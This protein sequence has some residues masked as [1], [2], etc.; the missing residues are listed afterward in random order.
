M[1]VNISFD[2]ASYDTDK[3][4]AYIA[5]YLRAF[6]SL[7]DQ[8]VRLLELGVKSGGSLLMWADFFP[9]GEVVGLDLN[10]VSVHHARVHVHRGYQQDVRVL[11]Q[12]GR[13]HAPHGFDIIIDDAS[14]LGEYTAASFSALY[15]HHLVPGGI[16]VLE[17]WGTGYW[18]TWP[19][20]KAISERPRTQRPARFDAS[21]RVVRKASRPAAQKLRSFPQLYARLERLYSATESQLAVVDFPS[22]SA[23]MVGFVKQLVDHTTITDSPPNEGAA[24]PDIAEMWIADGQ[25]FCFKPA[26]TQSASADS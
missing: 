26:Q 25:V 2:A 14:H 19:D 11:D 4:P 13:K 1:P 6:A 3:S 8:P 10:P 23:G 12:I 21:R 20:G 7:R 22:H 9:N 5:R 15:S 24:P 18:P 17:D 16:Y